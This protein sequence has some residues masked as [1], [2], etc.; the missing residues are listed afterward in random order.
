MESGVSSSYRLISFSGITFSKDGKILADDES[1]STLP[2]LPL[3]EKITPSFQII[4]EVDTEPKTISGEEI[5]DLGKHALKDWLTIR[6]IFLAGVSL[7]DELLDKLTE[8]LKYTFA[9]HNFASKKNDLASLVNASLAFQAITRGIERHLQYVS[10]DKYN[11]R[12]V[13]NAICITPWEDYLISSAEL[14]AEEYKIGVSNI[15]SFAASMAEMESKLKSVVF[16][17][18]IPYNEANMMHSLPASVSLFEKLAKISRCLEIEKAKRMKGGKERHQES[19]V[20]NLKA[21]KIWQSSQ[22][23]NNVA[24]LASFM[25]REHKI[26]LV[27][28]TLENKIRDWNNGKNQPENTNNPL[29]LLI[30]LIKKQNSYTLS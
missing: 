10:K 1:K 20:E 27:Q 28:R 4:L 14:V 5:A 9:A 13:V 30:T 2:S 25:I 19:H 6:T 11:A 15:Y 22:A 7:P 12:D 26:K 8:K 29:S 24:W 16:S 23:K 21:Y 17:K 18:P 3:V